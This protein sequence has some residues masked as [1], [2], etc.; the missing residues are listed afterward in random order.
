ME[1]M[2]ISMAHLR[3]LKLD[4]TAITH[5][6]LPSLQRM[7]YLEELSNTFRIG[8]KRKPDTDYEQDSEV[9]VKLLNNIRSLHYK[10]S[11]K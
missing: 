10:V 6:G 9:K 1:P 8:R 5:A 4:A 2:A 3:R 11:Q 7:D